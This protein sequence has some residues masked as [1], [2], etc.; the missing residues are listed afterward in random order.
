VFTFVGPLGT[1]G[2]VD[3][4]SAV[5]ALGFWYLQQSL[6]ALN[7]VPTGLP[8]A[9]GTS[10]TLRGVSAAPLTQNGQLVSYAAPLSEVWAQDVLNLSAT[11]DGWFGFPGH[12][13]PAAGQLLTGRYLEWSGLD[14]SDGVVMIEILS[15][16]DRL[17]AWSAL[18]P[19]GSTTF[20]IPDLA[21]APVADLASLGNFE[22]LVQGL[23]LQDA[24]LFDYNEHD[25]ALLA[26]SYWRARAVS[27]T[28]TFVAP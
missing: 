5:P 6:A 16:P 2:M 1:Q 3:F 25:N 12:T 15:S 18:L 27:S 22:W 28:Q 19:G 4:A 10:Y 11:L 17:P 9:Q 7:T 20:S 26:A 13:A 21:G 8:L 23:T 14:R 24:A